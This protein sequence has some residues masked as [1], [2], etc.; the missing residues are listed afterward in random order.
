MRILKRLL[1][2]SSDQQA[3]VELTP[4]RPEAHVQIVGDVHGQAELLHKLLGQLAT[5]SVIITVG[6][7]VDRGE[8]SAEVLDLIRTR[9][10]AEP[11]RFICLMGNHERMMLDFLDQPEKR[12][13]R[14]LRNGG[15]Q[16]LASFGVGG[17]SEASVGSA[18]VTA[19]DKL[20]DSMPD[21][22]EEWL[23][24]LPLCWSSGNLWVVHG[25]ADPALSMED[26]D[27]K[28]LLW[29]HGAFLQQPR[30]DGIWVA[31]GHTVVPLPEQRRSRIAVDTG[32]YYTGCLTAASVMPSG[33]VD[34][35][36]ARNPAR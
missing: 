14:W 25:A 35:I 13:A 19:R 6:D 4:C 29:G 9:Q 24:S 30:R 26:Q 8:A 28:V 3:E 5:D 33:E 7:Y 1:G 21:G 12:G 10:S 2:G 31:H 36:Q 16:T 32:A 15:L 18:M 20:R 22:T 23:R 17:V 34:F 27:E 11:D